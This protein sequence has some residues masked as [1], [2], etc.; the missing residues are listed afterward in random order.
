M[1]DFARYPSLITHYPAATRRLPDCCIDATIQGDIHL[2]KHIF[3]E[4]GAAAS[5]YFT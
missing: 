4:L 5:S 1:S 2:K 3:V